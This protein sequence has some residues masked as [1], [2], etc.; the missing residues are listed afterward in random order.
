MSLAAKKKEKE[1][2]IVWSMTR[3]ARILAVGASNA[4]T[5]HR[6]ASPSRAPRTNQG[7]TQTIPYVDG[8]L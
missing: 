5:N 8:N 6:R 2:N 1:H 7:Y 3:N 4:N